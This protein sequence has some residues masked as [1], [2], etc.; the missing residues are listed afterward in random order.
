MSQQP[1]LPVNN[2]RKANGELSKSFENVD[3]QNI[4][5]QEYLEMVVQQANTLPE[6]FTSPYHT[7]SPSSKHRTIETPI[8]GSAASLSYLVSDR[9]H[10]RQPPSA[11]F[12]PK[13]P[14][15]WVDHTLSNFSCLREYLERCHAQ[16]IGGKE[17]NR[18]HLPPMNDRSG[19]HIFCVGVDDARGNEG[20]YFD[21]HDMNSE[22]TKAGDD[23]EVKPPTWMSDLPTKGYA[24]SASLLLQ[25]DQVLVR[26]VRSLLIYYIKDGWA[27]TSAQRA[28]WIYGLLS[29]L[30][31]PIHREEAAVL[32][33]LLKSLTQTRADLDTTISRQELARVNVL[34]A[35]IGIYFEQGSG[36]AGLM[37][38]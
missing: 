9:T 5:A 27:P 1:C 20:S 8:H 23:G 11:A 22:E 37:T 12:L 31:R 29:R 3:I 18:L 21:D 6:V 24:P 25:M 17:T 34:I 10:I 14:E 28:E 35:I 36:F 19:W 4:D 7:D 32:F 33:G 16:G 38:A 26:R 13:V 15:Q 30:E 2:K